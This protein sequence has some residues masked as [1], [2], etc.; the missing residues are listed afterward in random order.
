MSAVAKNDSLSERN[1]PKLIL[2][3]GLA[4]S[5]STWLYNVIRLTIVRSGKMVYG[6][7]IGGYDPKRPE[8]YHLVKIH[9]FH[10]D[11][12]KQAFLIFVSHRDL[13]DVVAS[14]MRVGFID[15][16]I[17]EEDLAQWI[18]VHIQYLE[19]WNRLADYDMSYEKMMQ[20]RTKE[21][22]RIARILKMPGQAEQICYDVEH[23]SFGSKRAHPIHH[24]DTE[25]LLHE[26]HIAQ[27]DNGNQC[28]ILNLHLKEFV[29]KK[30]EH[31]LKQY[32]YE[33]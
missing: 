17:A 6:S 18:R 24:H 1:R 2:C 16:D 26:N 4:R 19:K 20:D 10:K 21:A 13:R 5:G 25:N 9:E 29:T 11:F 15:R 8:E 31:W 12:A 7:W 23:L 3:A 28:D 14:A 33:A 27:G 22:E 32:H 30:Y